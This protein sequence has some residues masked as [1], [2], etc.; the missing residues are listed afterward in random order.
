MKKIVFYMVIAMVLSACSAT[1]KILA[2]IYITQKDGN[3]KILNGIISKQVLETDTA[4]AWYVENKKYGQTNAEA[5]SI[6]SK[7]KEKFSLL[8]FGGT[9]CEDT[10]NLLPKFYKLIEKSGYPE[11]SITLVAVDREKKS[12][13]PLV[14]AYNIKNV[15]TFIIVQQGKEIA[16][17][18]EYGTMNDLEKELGQL[19]KG[20]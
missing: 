4:F 20:L 9:W 1:K 8:V 2:P 15:P 10:H 16:R 5:I 12:I 14:N 18:V 19:V 13:S 11:S 17:V 6:F 7:Q 3:T